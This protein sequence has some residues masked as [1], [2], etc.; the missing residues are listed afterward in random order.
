MDIPQ[1]ADKAREVIDKEQG[2]Q[3]HYM[4]RRH[5]KHPKGKGC[6]KPDYTAWGILQLHTLFFI[7]STFLYII[8]ISF[9][10][11][12]IYFILIFK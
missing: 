7:E 5:Q 2:Q 4:S 3:Y 9:K 10:K 11:L 12:I 8:I 1:I 6:L